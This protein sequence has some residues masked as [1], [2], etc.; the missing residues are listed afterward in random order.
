MADLTRLL[1]EAQA[2]NPDAREELFPMI[3]NELRQVAHNQLRKQQSGDI[4]QTT[5]LV[6]ECY[7]KLF[8]KERTG[9]KDRSHFFALAARAMRQI[10]V[11]YFRSQKAQKR[12]GDALPIDVETGDI[13]AEM[14]G[15]ILIALDEAL[16]KLAKLNSRLSDVVELKFFGGL[17]QKEIGEILDLT[18]RTVRNDWKKAQAWLAH[19]LSQV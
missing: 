16:Q 12:G 17:N 19:E 18:D 4:F 8:D 15:D 10:L 6:H 7:L 9:I 13:P 3:Y 2:G 11:D 5:A 14:R 1:L